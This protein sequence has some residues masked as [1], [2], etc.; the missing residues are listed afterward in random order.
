MKLLIADDEAVIRRGIL[1]LDWKAI[2]IDEV[3]AVSNGEEAKEILM[4]ASVDIVIFD[5]R[6]PGMTGLE[7]SAMIKEYSLDTAVVLLTGFSEFEYAKE[8]IS[9]GVYE[10]LLKPVNPKELLGCIAKVKGQLEEVRYQKA[11]V[12]KYEEREGVFDTVMQVRNHFAKSSSP[13]LDI[14]VNMAEE[15]T[16]SVSLNELAERHHF[17]SS[18]ISKKIKQD[19]GY[20]FIEILN[21]IRLM[22]AAKF[23]VEGDKVNRACEKAGFNDQRYF[24]QIFK[25]VFHCSP[26]DYK[27]HGNTIPQIRFHEILERISKNKWSREDGENDTTL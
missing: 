14:L 17:T 11:V 10:Y 1:S 7:L 8:A 16:Q 22:N 19:T 3:L 15:F 2:G 20:S 23:L 27:K 21:A 5:I 4:S 9:H 13:T 18:Y 26:S 6:M 12:H 25:R 24:S